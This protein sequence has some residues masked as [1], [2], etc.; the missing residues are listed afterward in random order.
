MF[1]E[2]AAASAAAG[3]IGPASDAAFAKKDARKTIVS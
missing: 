2:I 3:G 1:R